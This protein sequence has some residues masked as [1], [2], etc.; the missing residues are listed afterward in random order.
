M[1]A[2]VL[3]AYV[4]MHASVS[5][6]GMCVTCRPCVCMCMYVYV[7]E[8]LITAWDATACCRLLPPKH[9]RYIILSLGAQPHALPSKPSAWRGLSQTTSQL[10]VSW[11]GSLRGIN[12]HCECMRVCWGNLQVPPGY[13]FETNVIRACPMGLYREEYVKI[14]DKA[15]IACKSCMEGWT[16]YHIASKS[17]FECASECQQAPG[18]EEKAE[19]MQF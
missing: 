5:L 1:F 3:C 10:L 9:R 4:L 6:R 18:T 2:C 16:T 13:F 17:I 19:D 14:T 7:C 11:V 12:S 8:L 15:A